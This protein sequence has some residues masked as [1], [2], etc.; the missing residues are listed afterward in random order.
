MDPIEILR[1]EHKLVEEI[2]DELEIIGKLIR[3]DR[4]PAAE[5]ARDLLRLLREFVDGCHHA[6][7]ENLLFLLLEAKDWSMQAG[8]TMAM[9][10]EHA[11]AKTLI[12][13]MEHNLTRLYEDATAAWSFA[14]A[15]DAYVWL[16][17]AHIRKENDF[18]FTAAE[19]ILSPEE[20]FLLGEAFRL[21]D[22]VFGKSEDGQLL[23]RMQ[24]VTALAR[25][26]SALVG[27]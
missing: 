17:R 5:E 1:A 23:G 22:I 10:A 14:R 16:L 3:M 13:S 18:I 11:T 27:I 7:E 25:A 20:K 6:K 12:D 9:R 26:G 8:A 2:L 19:R 4:M 24:S 21:V 15:C